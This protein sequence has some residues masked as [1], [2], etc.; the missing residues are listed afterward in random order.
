M[1]P[2]GKWKSVFANGCQ[3]LAEICK[4]VVTL[5]NSNTQR[6]AVSRGKSESLCRHSCRVTPCKRPQALRL[7]TKC[8]R[9]A[10]RKSCPGIA[11]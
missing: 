11:G 6:L 1:V 8:G 4:P 10:A 5:E 7:W 3:T 9:A 2:Q